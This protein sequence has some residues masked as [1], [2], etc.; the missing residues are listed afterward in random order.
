MSYPWHDHGDRIRTEDSPYQQ[1][2]REMSWA[3]DGNEAYWYDSARRQATRDSVAVSGLRVNRAPQSRRVAHRIAGSLS[4]V[5]RTTVATAAMGGAALAGT[6]SRSVV[7]RA[8]FTRSI[9]TRRHQHMVRVP[10]RA[11]RTRPG[12]PDIR[13]DPTGDRPFEVGSLDERARPGLGCRQRIDVDDGRC[14][15]VHRPSAPHRPGPC[16]PRHDAAGGALGRSGPSIGPA[17]GTTARIGTAVRP[18]VVVAGVRA[19]RPAA[20]GAARRATARIGTALR[21]AFDAAVCA[22]V[23][24][25]ADHGTHRHRPTPSG[26]RRPWRGDPPHRLDTAPVRAVR[27]CQVSPRPHRHFR[28]GRPDKAL[29]VLCRR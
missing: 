21:S 6:R 2:A 5:H 10:G 13:R 27:T 11:A 26:P 17:R 9:V 15:P 18:A 12:Q 1:G 4:F 29:S 22:A 16:R 7:I 8:I 20:V 14:A 23:G 25:P 3:G 28:A 24:P 19:A